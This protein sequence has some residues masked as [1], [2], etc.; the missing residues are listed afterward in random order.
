MGLLHIFF[1]DEKILAHIAGMPLGEKKS[2]LIAKFSFY[3]A[4]Q[5]LPQKYPFL[6]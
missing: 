4:S 5:G 1:I 6:F 2:A 3:L